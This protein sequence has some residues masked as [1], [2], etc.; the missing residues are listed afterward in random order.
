MPEAA[1][2]A[3]A[4]A[5]LH[6]VAAGRELTAL[7]VTHPRTVRHTDPAAV[8]ALVGR[9]VGAVR[10]HGKWIVV[11]LVGSDASLGVH[12]RMSGQ[13]LLAEPGTPHPDRHV[14][15]TLHLGARISCL[16]DIPRH[17]GTKFPV[18]AGPVD[19]WFRDP[20]TFGELRVLPGGVAP[21][22]P[23]LFDPAVT[24]SSLHALAVRRRVGVKAVLLDQTQGAAGI[25]SYLADEALHRAG[26]DPTVPSG[27]LA[28]SAW[29]RILGAARAIAAAS[30]A[31]GGVTLE[32]EG[33][34]DLWGRPG[35]Y[36]AELQVHA[37]AACA[38][39]GTP[40]SS[41][42]VGGRRARWCRRC[43]HPRRR[44]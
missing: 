16:G 22:A 14:H 25:G 34:I 3:V 36:A 2:V 44:R 6:Q 32:D 10:S 33:W 43:Q 8:A 21:V 13:L 26:I 17:P 29:D 1:E 37:R 35:A 12:L 30:M 4:A 27:E 41:A 9:R 11:E 28:V 42:V 38:V 7:P 5:Q 20:R 24:G 19:V 15:A 23:D 40:T 39:C 18:G 31:A